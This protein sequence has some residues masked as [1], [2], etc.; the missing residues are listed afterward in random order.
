MF[1]R[2]LFFQSV[3]VSALGL[4]TLILNF[5]SGTL[6]S[7]ITFTRT[8]LATIY[9]NT[10]KLTYAPNN[11]LLHS[12]DFANAN[13]TKQNVTL[14][15]GIDDPFGGTSAFTFTATAANAQ[16]FQSKVATGQFVS[17]YY[18]RRRAGS[19]VVNA[20]TPDGNTNQSIA[21]TGAWQ[22][23]SANG[24]DGTGTIYSLIQIVT[25]GDAIDV[26]FFQLEAVTYEITPR[27]YNATTT[28]AYHGPRFDHNPAAMTFVTPTELL[29]NGTF[30]TNLTGW[31]ARLPSSSGTIT[32]VGGECLIQNSP[33]G[34]YQGPE[35]GVST[36]VGRSYRVTATARTGTAHSIGLV[37]ATIAGG[38]DLGTITTTSLTNVTLTLTFV[39]TTTTSYISGYAA[40]TNNG[41]AY[42]DNVSVKLLD[43]EPLGLLIEQSRTNLCKQSNNLSSVA[44]YWYSD[45]TLAL[46]AIGPTGAN[47]AWTVSEIGV[48]LA[49][50]AFF[51]LYTNSGVGTWTASLFL[52]QRGRRYV[53]VSINTNS[54]VRFDLQRGVIES[55]RGGATGTIEAGISGGWRCTVTATGT[56]DYLV[57]S[58]ATT[59]ALET[60]AIE[61]G[62]EPIVGIN[63]PAFDVANIQL[64]A[65]AFAT[66][67]IPTGAT[68]VT[69]AADVASITGMNFSSW[70]NHAEGTWVLEGDGPG[71]GSWAQ[72][73]STQANVVD[74]VNEGSI[75]RHA[76]GNVEF[77]FGGESLV[78]GYTIVSGVPIKAVAGYA[79]DNKAIS[80]NGAAATTGVGAVSALQ[81]SMKLGTDRSGG[82]YLNGHIRSLT[83]L[84]TRKTNAELATLSLIL[85][86][87]NARGNAYPTSLVMV[88]TT[89]TNYTMPLT[90]LSANGTSYIFV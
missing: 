40:V 43:A 33:S 52:R 26:A 85:G 89:N 59:T 1:R 38:N 57:I 2:S 64:E 51:P 6:D 19:G 60:V 16:V 73:F 35:Q 81:T 79:V 5:L 86:T 78:T 47:G 7:R 39:A 62:L 68:T 17:S 28:S 69:R 42:I 80:V 58:S 30:D 45:T 88:S 41:T 50:R 55:S 49:N 32:Q 66:S 34:G 84:S 9:D 83:Y 53:N 27:A 71:A 82:S 11:L 77:N 24:S 8:S 56:H 72:W 18:A 44:E 48:H 12:N 70:Y 54:V 15:S 29:T 37:A 87:M 74:Y 90:A 31:Y 61:Y 36:V 20:R 75:R 65:G 3:S 10:G 76:G 25:S 14:T 23:F 67:Y 63:G 4:S 46:N 22:R 13:W 21:L